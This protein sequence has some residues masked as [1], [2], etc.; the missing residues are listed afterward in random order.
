MRESR[1]RRRPV[2][3]VLLLLW[4]RYLDLFTRSGFAM[5]RSAV[6]RR[7]PFGAL[8]AFIL[9]SA[10]PYGVLRADETALR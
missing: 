9:I 7:L 10:V 1:R 2:D 3:S 8:R 5:S 6:I 4:N